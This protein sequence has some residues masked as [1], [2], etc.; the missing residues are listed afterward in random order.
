MICMRGDNWLYDSDESDVDRFQHFLKY[1]IL[2]YGLSTD[3]LSL[4]LETSIKSTRDYLAERK[5]MPF[6]FYAYIRMW[7]QC[8]ADAG[9]LQKEALYY[10]THRMDDSKI[11]WQ[12]RQN[13]IGLLTPY[14]QVHNPPREELR[15][16][17]EQDWAA[18]MTYGRR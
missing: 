4:M 6:P 7:M 13:L 12:K 8:H 5:R 2:V 9:P 15:K 11:I 17:I 1:L 18:V 10:F 14:M 3:R 16:K